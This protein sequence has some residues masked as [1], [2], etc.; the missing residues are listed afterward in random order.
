[1]KKRLKKMLSLNKRHVQKFRCEPNCKV[2]G[3]GYRVSKRTPRPKIKENT[4][5]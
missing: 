3:L 5:A 2:C 4:P 1:M